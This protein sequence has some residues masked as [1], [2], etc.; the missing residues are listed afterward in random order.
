MVPGS[1]TEK[2]T[3]EQLIQRLEAIVDRLE[4]NNLPLE[5]AIEAYQAGVLLAKE[6]HGRLADA[7]RRIEEVTRAGEARPLD[8]QRVLSSGGED[9]E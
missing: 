3:F 9:P 1:P 7:E 6:G 4:S 5:E 8:L 2:P